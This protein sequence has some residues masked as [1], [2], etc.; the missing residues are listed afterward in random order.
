MR[1]ESGFDLVARDRGVLDGVVQVADDL[2]RG[3][4]GREECGDRVEVLV[5]GECTVGLIAVR[6][7]GEGAASAGCTAARWQGESAGRGM[8]SP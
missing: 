2:R 1:I 3:A 4:I 8:R 7:D 5:A 6:S